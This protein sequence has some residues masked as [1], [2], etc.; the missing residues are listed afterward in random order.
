[1]LII[2]VIYQ[3]VKDVENY[4]NGVVLETYTNCGHNRYYPFNQYQTLIQL[5]GCRVNNPRDVTLYNFI[6]FKSFKVLALIGSTYRTFYSE[7]IQ[8]SWLP[9]FRIIYFSPLKIFLI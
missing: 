4:I 9:K 8:I 7:K 3:F 5:W 2:K 1:V 6:N